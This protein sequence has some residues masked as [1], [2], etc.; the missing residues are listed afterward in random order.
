MPELVHRLDAARVGVNLSAV[1][2]E[3]ER[4]CA[5][6][7]R[8]P[9][10]VQVLAAVKYLSTESLPVLAE[11]GVRLV[12]ENRAQQL[13]VKHDA[14]PD[15]FAW[16]FIGELQSK[17]V[18]LVAPRVRLIHSL[19]T[20]SAIEELVRL[21]EQWRAGL[22]ALVQV[23]VSGEPA[24]AG[25]QPG[26]LEEFIARC[27]LP[28]RGL[29]TMPPHSEDPEQSRRWFARLREL[30]QV[31]GLRELS[32]GTSQDFAV[33]AEEGATIVRIGTRLYGETP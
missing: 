33:A 30:A 19:C 15:L 32:M 25:V 3:I 24:K 29:S 26:A 14:H 18:R 10:A 17:H 31:H 5:R 1:R 21:R 11:A 12:G 7:G 9:A 8:D 22:A 4:A 13:K 16:D 2:A 6:A 27:P 20:D 28:V 23:N